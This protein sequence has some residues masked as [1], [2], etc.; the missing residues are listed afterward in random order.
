MSLRKFILV[1]AL[2]F[3]VASLPLAARL[4]SHSGARANTCAVTNDTDSSSRQQ[5]RTEPCVVGASGSP[6]GTVPC[7]IELIAQG[8]ENALGF[9]LIFL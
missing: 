4:S 2:I 6:G 8:D 9:S 3:L 7:P 1:L 5:P